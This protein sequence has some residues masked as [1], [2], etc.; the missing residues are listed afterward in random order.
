MVRVARSGRY[1]VLAGRERAIAELTETG[2]VAAVAR[3]RH[4]DHPQAEG[5][6]VAKDGA[7]LVADEGGNGRGTLSVYRPR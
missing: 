5:L 3:L 6:A 4:H 1:L 7:L 2:E